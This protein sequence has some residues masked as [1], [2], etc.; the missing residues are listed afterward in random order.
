VTSRV[1]LRLFKILTGVLLGLA[2]VLLLFRLGVSPD[3]GND[4]GNFL[5]DPIPAPSFTLLSHTGERVASTEFVGKHLIVFFGY[6]Y[7]PDVCPLTLSNLSRALADM[8]GDAGRFQVILVSVD[9]ARDTPER[10]GEYLSHFNPAFLGL[11]GSEE[12]IRTVASGFG[13]Y[14]ARAGGGDQYT[15]DHTARVFVVS[16]SGKIP[17]TFPVTATPQ[18]MAR[19]LAFLLEDSP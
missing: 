9:P 11:T 16:P 2:L 3:A 12:E 10:L 5:P 18:E 19:E 4:H 13:A 14:F 17:L 8:G 6:T 7:C 15:V 1:L